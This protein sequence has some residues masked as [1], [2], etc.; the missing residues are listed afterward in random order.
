[1]ASTLTPA[2][3]E[4]TVHA[5]SVI[6]PLRNPADVTLKHFFRDHRKSFT[7]F[8]GLGGL[9]SGVNRKQIRL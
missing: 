6:L 4:A 2:L 8:S 7:V 3:L 9:N 5:V 1:M